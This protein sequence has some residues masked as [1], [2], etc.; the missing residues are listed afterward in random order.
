MIA[1]I[2]NG[3]RPLQARFIPHKVSVT[4]VEIHIP[5]KRMKG[6]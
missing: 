2:G 6:R 4:R 3:E 1:A 5:G